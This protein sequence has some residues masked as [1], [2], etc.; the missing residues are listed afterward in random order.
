MHSPELELEKRAHELRGEKL[1]A[2]HYQRGIESDDF[3][4]VGHLVFLDFK[5]GRRV[6]IGCSDELRYRHGWGISV[7]PQRVIDTAY[8]KPKDVSKSPRWSSRIGRTI[9]QAGIH[10]DDIKEA[11]RPT[12]AIGVAIHAD[13]LSRLDYPQTLELDFGDDN[14][15]ENKVL[16][17][18][19]RRSGTGAIP[20]VNQLLVFFSAES[21]SAALP[22]KLR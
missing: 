19:A 7:K 15:G 3:D 4:S 6:A 18:A 11:L 22:P 20:F 1:K 9:T 10:W 5:S 21:R 17:A 12:L 13:H 2:V 16:I 8:G 14:E